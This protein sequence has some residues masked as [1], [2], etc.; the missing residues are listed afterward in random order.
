MAGTM[1]RA[2][3]VIAASVLAATAAR[4]QEGEPFQAPKK[5]GL[6]VEAMIRNEWTKEIFDTPTE[7]HDDDRW[8]LRLMPR[9]TAGGNRFNVV[10]G[11]DLNYSKDDNIDPLDIGEKPRILRDNYQSRGIR[12]DLATASL[13]PTNWFKIEGGRFVMPVALTEMIWDRD[14]RPQGGAVRLSTGQVG[15]IESLHG[16]FVFSE[17]GHVFDDGKTR[18]MIGS[19]GAR[20]KA[21]MSNHL[22]ITGS[23]LE[24]K[25]LNELEGMI[26]RQNTRTPDADRFLLH[27]F[28]VADVVGRIQAGGNVPL[29]LVADMAW[30][31]RISENNRG[32]WLAVVLG[33]IRVSRARLEYTYANV[34]KDATVAAF[35]TDDFFWG[36]GWEG[37]RVE[38]GTRS[39]SRFTAHLI[40]QLQR[41]KDSTIEEER[42]HWVKRF[43]VEMRLVP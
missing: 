28:R 1:P 37:H 19:A 34:D 14:L 33:S 22:E 20:L 9:I 24:F 30:N 38:L 12:L 42:D 5:G 18:I 17:G 41:F 4:A 32:V 3:L 16:A 43:R 21:G 25:N 7:F 31:T 10:V 35:A 6:E 29:Q 2:A 13:Q 36:T 23:I 26:R 8:R 39:G 27:P 40:G 15:D 11:G